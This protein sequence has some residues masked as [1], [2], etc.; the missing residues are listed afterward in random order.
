VTEAVR[1]LRIAAG[2][3]GVG[4]LADGRTVFVPRAAPGDLIEPAEVRLHARFARAQV[5]RILEPGPGRVRPRCSHY[6][7]DDCGGCQLQH[8]D[9]PGQHAARR[10]ITGDALRRIARL[11]LDDPDLESTDAE[12]N[13]R[14]RITLAVDPRGPVAGFHR[15]ADPDA[16]FS[17]VRCEIADERLNTAWS[18]VSALTSAWPAALSHIVLR[19]GRDDGVHVVFRGPV[20]PA[21]SWGERSDMVTWWEAPD[22]EPRRLNPGADGVERIPPG[23]FEQVHRVMGA[24]VR[25]FAVEQLG[26]VQGKLVWDLYAGIGETSSALAARGALVE[27]VE[28][29]PVAVAA[30][31]DAGNSAVVRH[32]GTVEGW[33]DRMRPPRAVIANP[34]RAGMAESVTRAL[35]ARRPDR[36]VY[37]SC[38]P[39]TLARD[40]LRLRSAYRVTG[41][42]CFDLFPQTAHVETVVRLDQA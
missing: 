32:T 4:R 24:R 27:S 40:L 21:P 11:S 39:A 36:L 30:T 9:R 1:I 42:R 34:P 28:L 23:V 41:L 38:D 26:P 22:A 3:D 12:W 15:A 19:L 6:R 29:D 10:A 17:L 35:V 5:G 14:S 18:A 13:Y 33:V 37:I 7:D 25:D 31:P 8:L 2:G 20:K 16:V